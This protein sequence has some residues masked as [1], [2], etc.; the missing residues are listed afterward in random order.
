MDI[1]IFQASNPLMVFVK[2]DKHQTL[3]D[4]MLYASYACRSVQELECV[5]DPRLIKVAWGTIAEDVA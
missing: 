3:H 1:Q 5:F 2:P 4:A